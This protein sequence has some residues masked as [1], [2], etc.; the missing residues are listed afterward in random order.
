MIACLDACVLFPTVMRQVLLGAA[1]QGAF[2]PVWSTRIVEEWVRAA[3]RDGPAAKLLAEGEAALLRATWPAA[4]VPGGPEADLWL[5]DP[6]DIHVLATARQAG[7]AV[8]VT[9]NLKDFPARSLA[10]LD[11]RADHPDA[12]LLGLWRHDPSPVVTAAEDAQA[13]AKAAGAGDIPLRSLLKRAG[14]PRLGKALGA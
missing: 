2:T 10:P 9:A 6:A 3:G 13:R 4:E 8:I 14:L 5:P 11:I 12:F 7:A 1:D